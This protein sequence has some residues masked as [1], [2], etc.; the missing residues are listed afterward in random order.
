MVI[1]ET[2]PYLC[3]KP[4]KPK[5]KNRI[6]QK[7]YK[8][9]RIKPKKPNAQADFQHYILALGTAVMIPAVLVPMMGGS[10]VSAPLRFLIRATPHGLRLASQVSVPTMS[11]GVLGLPSR[12]GC[13]ETG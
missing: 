2:E 6:N 11:G 9:N 8:P 1:T 12:M 5:Y 10:D 7:P 3:I 13:R 4:Y